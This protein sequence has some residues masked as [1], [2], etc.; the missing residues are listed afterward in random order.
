MPRALRYGI[1]IAAALILASSV[2]SCR[3]FQEI[4]TLRKVDFAID[5]ITDTRLADID[6]EDIQSYQDLRPGHLA[7]ITTALAN[8]ELPLAFNLQLTAANPRDNTVSA[9]LVNMDWTLFL[10]DRETIDGTI[11]GSTVIPPGETRQISVPIRLDLV[12]FFQQNTRDL[13][14]LAMAVAG[15]SDT[16]VPVTLQ[17]T[18]IIQTRL[19]EIPYSGPITIEHR[20][21]GSASR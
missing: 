4:T 15:Q 8:N 20:E 5:R 16:P 11:D 21:I 14:N 19:G 6:L 9:R 7:R 18:P 1:C 17:A 12:R 13:L 2:S 3:Y 10:N